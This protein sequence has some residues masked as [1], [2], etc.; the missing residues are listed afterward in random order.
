MNARPL[1]PGRGRKLDWTSV[2]DGLDETG[3]P[4][5]AWL[6]RALAHWAA[7]HGDPETGFQPRNRTVAAWLGRGESAVTEWRKGNLW[8]LEW[9]GVVRARVGCEPA[10]CDSPYADEEQLFSNRLAAAEEEK[11]KE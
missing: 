8:N 1:P 3:R 4:H 2:T 7:G 11:E 5:T 10:T 9:F 6:W